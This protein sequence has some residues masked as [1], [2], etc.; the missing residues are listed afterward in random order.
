[1]ADKDSLAQNYGKNNLLRPMVGNGI[2]IDGQPHLLPMVLKKGGRWD[3]K[4][5]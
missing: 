3:G 5:H 1:M 4:V 2:I